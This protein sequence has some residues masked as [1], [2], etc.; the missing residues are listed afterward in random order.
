MFWF[1]S[2][3]PVILDAVTISVRQAAQA[4]QLHW[5]EGTFTGHVHF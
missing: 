2:D 3:F 4:A 1:A 5:I